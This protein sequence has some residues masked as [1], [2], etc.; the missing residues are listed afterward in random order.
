MILILKPNIDAE[1]REF[2][3][4]EEHLKKTPNIEMRVHRVQGAEQTLTEVYLIG[5]TAA[6]SL[7]EM[8]SFPGVEHAVRVSEEYRV[9]GRHKDDNRVESFHIQRRRIFAGQSQCFCRTVR[10]R[11]ARI[12]SKR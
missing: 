8:K 12:A 10:G 4:I 5:N 6:L 2:Q 9:L 3:R 1:S 11:F 7:D